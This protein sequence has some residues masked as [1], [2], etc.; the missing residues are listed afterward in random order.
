MA[1]LKLSIADVRE[2][3]RRTARGSVPP[4]GIDPDAAPEPGPD[5][6][7]RRAIRQRLRRTRAVRRARLSELGALVAQ[8]HAQGRWN[9]ELVDGWVRE[10]DAAD[11]ELRGLDQALRGQ[12]PLADLIA[13]RLVTQCGACGRIGGSGDAF[14]AGCGREL[15]KTAPSGETGHRVDTT[16]VG[17]LADG[18]RAPGRPRPEASTGS[19]EGSRHITTIHRP[20]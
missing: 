13:L 14:C 4:A 3:A 2:R 12:V 8:M 1:K 5:G 9:Q 7:S 15:P 6:R 19:A 20:A 17:D 11:A 10:L 18:Y 16:L